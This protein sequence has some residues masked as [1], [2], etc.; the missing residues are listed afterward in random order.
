MAFWAAFLPS[1][2]WRLTSASDRL[3][4]LRGQNLESKTAKA[5]EGEPL[6]FELGAPLAL[7]VT[8]KH[9]CPPRDSNQ[10]E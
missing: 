6:R 4:R 3:R 1:G 7:G 8:W 10:L 5:G 2:K 9:S